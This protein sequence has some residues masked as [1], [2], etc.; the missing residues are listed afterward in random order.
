RDFERDRALFHRLVG[1]VEAVRDCLDALHSCPADKVDALCQIEDR[2]AAFFGSDA[3]AK[4]RLVSRVAK[5]HLNRAEFDFLGRLLC[6]WYAAPP[7]ALLQLTCE[8]VP[9][10]D[11]DAAQDTAPLDKGEPADG[12]APSDNP[13]PVNTS[14]SADD[15]EADPDKVPADKD[16]QADDPE[17]ARGAQPAS[18]AEHVATPD[19]DTSRVTEPVVAAANP[20]L[21]AQTVDFVHEV[22]LPH[23]IRRLTMARE[24]CTLAEAELRMIRSDSDWVDQILAARETRS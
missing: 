9:T 21:A 16:V 4:R 2:M 23:A 20:K 19:S 10:D 6:R 1:E 3:V 5:G 18:D 17:L 24:Q 7:R 12:A 13:E 22:L 8:S 15:A 11:A 14:V